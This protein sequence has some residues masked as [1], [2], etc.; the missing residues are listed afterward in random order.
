MAKLVLEKGADYDLITKNNP[1]YSSKLSKLFG[2]E[3]NDFDELI[4]EAKKIE[5]DGYAF[6]MPE[7]ISITQRDFFAGR[8]K[9][10]YW[11]VKDVYWEGTIEQEV[12]RIK[13]LP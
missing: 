10:E 3:F 6:Y 2:R 9:L 8:S 7:N 4:Q 1:A 5:L 13:L 12:A 11:P